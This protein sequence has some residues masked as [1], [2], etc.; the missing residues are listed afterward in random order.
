MTFPLIGALS[1]TEIIVLLAT[2]VLF[3]LPVAAI[4]LIIYFLTKP[5]RRHREQ[6][7]NSKQEDVRL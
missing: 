1:L 7:A 5:A 2:L 4:G 3:A 6:E